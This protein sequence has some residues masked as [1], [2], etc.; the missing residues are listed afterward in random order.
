M[1]DQTPQPKR[2][3]TLAYLVGGMIGWFL[4]DGAALAGASLITYGVS[5]I[6]APAGFIAAGLFLLIGAWLLARKGDA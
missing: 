5:R 2:R 3:K 1:T 4:Q 6:Y